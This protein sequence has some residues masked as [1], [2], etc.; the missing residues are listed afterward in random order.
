[1]KQRKA[2]TFLAQQRSG[3]HVPGACFLPTALLL[4]LPLPVTVIRTFWCWSF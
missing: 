4:L 2:K 1:M 3:L